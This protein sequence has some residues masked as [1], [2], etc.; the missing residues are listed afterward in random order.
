[1]PGST[2]ECAKRVVRNVASWHKVVHC[3]RAESRLCGGIKGRRGSV[4]GW[5]GTRWADTVRPG[6]AGRNGAEPYR[7]H[8]IVREELSAL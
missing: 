4:E 6:A 1:M 2:S 7:P 8:R 3:R 5:P